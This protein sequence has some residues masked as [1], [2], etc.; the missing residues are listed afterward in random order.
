[1]GTLTSDD[2]S[3]TFHQRYIVEVSGHA[4][5]IVVRE[6]GGFRFFAAAGE[7]TPLNRLLFVSPGRAEDA[8]R[9]LLNVERR[10]TQGGRNESAPY[11]I[12]QRAGHD[13][14]SMIGG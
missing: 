6:R 7:V 3:P 4:V 1:M 2:F 14:S 11:R 12:M 13:R 8:C 5:G 9:G 10:R